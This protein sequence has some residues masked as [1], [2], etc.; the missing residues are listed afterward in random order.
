MKKITKDKQYFRCISGFFRCFEKKKFTK[1]DFSP[2][3]YKKSNGGYGLAGVHHGHSLPPPLNSF[4]LTRLRL[5]TAV[6]YN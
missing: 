3:T 5:V 4:P 2:L 6:A 1:L